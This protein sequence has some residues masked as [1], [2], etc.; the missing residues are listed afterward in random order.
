MLDAEAQS[1]SAHPT[2]RALHRSCVHS[3]IAP[4]AEGAAALCDHLRRAHDVTRG[5]FPERCQLHIATLRQGTFAAACKV[6][7]VYGI[8]ETGLFFAPADRGRAHVRA[9]LKCLAYAP[10]MQPAEAPAQRETTTEDTDQDLT[11]TSTRSGP[12]PAAARGISKFLYPESRLRCAA[13]IP[14][15]AV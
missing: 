12:P 13:A 1:S 15:A 11:N 6:R 2:A 7:T 8:D 10:V 4:A 3:Q 14:H 9:A 5:A